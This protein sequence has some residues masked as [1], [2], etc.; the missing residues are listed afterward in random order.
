[1]AFTSN[2]TLD[3]TNQ[4]NGDQ[5]IL[6]DYKHAANLF[7]ADQ[8]RLAPKNQILISCV[9][10][11]QLWRITKCTAGSALRSRNQH[12]GQEYRLAKFYHGYCNIKSV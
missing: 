7:T 12:V 3:A 6:K 11:H 2:P 10:Q 4:L 5:V 1:M 8:F 9:V